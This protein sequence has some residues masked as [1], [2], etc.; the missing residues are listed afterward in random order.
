[1]P[2]THAETASCWVCG[3]ASRPFRRSTIREQV[4]SASVRITDA[5]YGQTAALSRCQVCGFV[6]ADPVPHGDI[7][8]LYRGMDDQ[9]YQESSAARRAQMRA[10]LDVVCTFRPRARTLLDI[11]AGTGL[12]VAEAKA[13]GLDAQGVEPSRWCVETASAMNQVDLLCGTMEE[14]RDQLGHYDIV[15]LVDVI[16]HTTDPLA[17]LREAAARLAP[18]GALL[19]VTPD[20]GSVAARLM[21][22]WWWHHRIAHVGYFDR[23][24]MGRALQEA[25][26]TLEADRP[27]VWRFPVTYILERLV[28][29][30]PVFP[31]STLLRRASRSPRLQQR[32]ISVNLRDSQAFIASA[33]G[34]G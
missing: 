14:W 34:L 18:A 13:R 1:M 5:N 12:L 16:E 28:R 7:V 22:R 30:L 29:Y 2:P 24:S 6:F 26:L 8:G 10:L 23:A 3:G 32:Q 9:P 17:M 27:A 21:G 19:I 11:G 31:I 20:I 33:A 15:T 4:D 25:R